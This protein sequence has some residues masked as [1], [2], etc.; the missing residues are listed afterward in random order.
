[1]NISSPSHNF[2]HILIPQIRHILLKHWDPIGI[3]HLEFMQDE[4]DGYIPRIIEMLSAT[5]S[6]PHDI[7]DYLH[8]VE[9]DYMNLHPNLNKIHLTAEAL[10]KLSHPIE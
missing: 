8:Y 1:M 6:H 10:W 5:N 9:I 2:Y 4:Y 7:Q 3:G